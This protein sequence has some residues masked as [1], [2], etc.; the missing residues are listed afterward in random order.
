MVI[1]GEQKEAIAVRVSDHA[2]I[3]QYAIFGKMEWRVRP[4]RF[5]NVA[6]SR[7]RKAAAGSRLGFV[8]G[9]TLIFLLVESTPH[10]TITTVLACGERREVFE[11]AR[12]IYHFGGRVQG[13]G[14]RYTTQNIAMRY[15]VHGYVRNLNDGRVELVMEGDE[16]EMDEVVGSLQ[17]RMNGYIR[18]IESEVAPATGEFQEFMI[19]H[20]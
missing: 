18:R 4:F 12:R 19:R 3:H 11:M 6:R 14:F 20:Y 17:Q 13:V 5:A 2:A 9:A 16:L 8:N 10:D 15:N 1:L 7:V